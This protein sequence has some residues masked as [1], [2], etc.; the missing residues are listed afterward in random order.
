MSV[1]SELK[2]KKTV[3]SREVFTGSEHVIKVSPAKKILSDPAATIESTMKDLGCRV[4]RSLKEI[5]TRVVPRSE[6][7]VL[8]Q[9]ATITTLNKK[10]R[11]IIL[12][13]CNLTPGMIILFVIKNIEFQTDKLNR[14]DLNRF[15]IDA[16]VK[17]ST[18][19]LYK[20]LI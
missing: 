14:S 7:I 2:K 11:I 6:Q 9:A 10:I 16:K 17:S 13:P 5:L 4:T 18:F 15:I 19:A 1:L 3:E 20:F 8:S 12:R